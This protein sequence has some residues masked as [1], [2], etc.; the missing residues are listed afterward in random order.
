ML[1]S[2]FE[3]SSKR[4]KR[5]KNAPFT[6]KLDQNP[7]KSENVYIVFSYTSRPSFIYTIGGRLRQ[8]F[9]FRIGFLNYL[10]EL[11]TV[12]NLFTS[13]SEKYRR[14]ELRK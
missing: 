14:S 7:N 5:V 2:L 3:I 12:N 4:I 11:Q 9:Y 8:Y 13:V 1:S 10:I 6:L